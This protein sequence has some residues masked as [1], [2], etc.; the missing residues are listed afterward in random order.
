MTR[1]PVDSSNIKSL[2]YDNESKAL[3]VEFTNGAVYRYSGVGKRT[4]E[5]LME[6]KSKGA[7]FHENIRG[8]YSYERV[9]TSTS[10]E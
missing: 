5:E 2:G 9:R 7:F 4:F 10:D 8:K 6:T 3:E 1:T